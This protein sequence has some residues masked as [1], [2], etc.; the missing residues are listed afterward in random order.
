MMQAL[1]LE[2]IQQRILFGQYI[3]S[4]A[5]K[6]TVCRDLNG[7][8]AQFLS[9]AQH[10]LGIRCREPL[11]DDWSA[12]LVKSWTVRGTM[13]VFCEEDLSLFLHNGRT[14]HLRDVDKLGSDDHISAERKQMFADLIVRWIGEGTETREELKERCFAAGMTETESESVFNAWGGTIRALA[15]SGKLAYRVQE[16]KAFQLCRP[17]VPMEKDV[18]E[19]ELARRYFAHFGPAS[20][21]DAAYYFGTTQANVKRWMKQLPL[22]EVQLNGVSRFYIDSGETNIP[23]I[24]DCVFLAG[25]DQLMLGYRKE[26][27]LFL[28]PE[29][30]R[31]VFN[32]AGIVFPTVLLRGRVAAKWKLSGKKLVIT[33]FEPLTEP[34]RRLICIAVEETFCGVEKIVWE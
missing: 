12:G 26:E 7:L 22:N 8:Q 18:A 32:L 10:A 2:E 27:S 25:F 6:E 33:A 1:K 11:K 16:Q 23:D 15:E 20:V 28:P 13:H 24:P 19:L 5:D 31:G 14:N 29:Y 9:N 21:R 4:K 3:T 34:D 17:F 30:L